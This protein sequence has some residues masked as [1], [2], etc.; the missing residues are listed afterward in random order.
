M[1]DDVLS[2]HCIVV[3]LRSVDTLIILNV[4]TPDTSENSDV[5]PLRFKSSSRE[6]F[7]NQVTPVASSCPPMKQLKVV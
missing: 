2:T 6:L 7:I 3:E 4:A 1:S 5:T